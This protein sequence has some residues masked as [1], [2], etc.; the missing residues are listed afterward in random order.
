MSGILIL[1]ILLSIIQCSDTTGSNENNFS[2]KLIVKDLDGDPIEDL[3]IGFSNKIQYI[4]SENRI[5]TNIYYSLHQDCFLSLKIYDFSDNLI[6]T[7][8]YSNQLQ[9]INFYFKFF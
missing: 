1:I 8:I 9:K 2:I 3:D 5:G 7:L 6:K 4:T